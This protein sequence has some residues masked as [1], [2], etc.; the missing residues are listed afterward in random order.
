LTRWNLDYVFVDEHNRHKRL[1]G[2]NPVHAARGRRR[3]GPDTANN[4]AQL[5]ELAKDVGDEKSSATLPLRILGHVQLAH[6]S[7][8]TV[9]RQCYS[10]TVNS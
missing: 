7:N 1:K 5:C 6:D 10:M 2:E 9:Y 8:Y 4:R 3:V